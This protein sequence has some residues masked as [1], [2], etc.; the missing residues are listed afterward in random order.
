[1]LKGCLHACPAS[2]PSPRW[3]RGIALHLSAWFAWSGFNVSGGMHD[4]VQWP[5]RYL[6]YCTDSDFA[7]AYK[8]NG[9]A[10]LTRVWGA[11]VRW[12]WHAGGACTTTIQ[13][14]RASLQLDTVLTN[15]STTHG[16]P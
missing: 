2:R 5:P 6:P 1:M 13:I 14:S 12:G 16:K 9:H 11:V 15:L 8:G 10:M 4:C 3:G 7:A